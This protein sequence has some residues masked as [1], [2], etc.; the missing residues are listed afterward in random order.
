MAHDRAFLDDVTS[1]TIILRNASL[2]YHEGSISATE[3]AIMK[4]RKGM[5]RM[6]EGLDK[7][8]AHIEKGIAENMVRARRTHD[9]KRA[10]AAKSKQK[11]LDERYGVEVNQKGQR[12]V[13]LTNHNMIFPPIVRPV[14]PQVQA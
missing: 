9:D 1:E 14:I 4:K 8:R 5:I 3:R 13:S 11:K 2:S 10:R 6:K 7:R 12:C